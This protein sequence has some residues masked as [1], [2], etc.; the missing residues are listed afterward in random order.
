MK[1]RQKAS[2]SSTRGGFTLIELVASM[3]VLSV[4][5]LVAANVIMESMR[6]YA[7]A[8]PAMDA[9]YKSNLALRT[10]LRD[11]RD[12]DDLGSISTFGNTAFTFQDSNDTT[13]AYL[14]SGGRLTRNGDLLTDDV[15]SLTFSYLQK[16][17]TTASDAED[18]YLVEVDLT[19]RCSDQVLRA[20]TIA[21]PRSLG[22]SL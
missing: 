16:D 12:L 2:H 5:A 10:M 9:S 7:R 11:I 18:L 4:I 14:L 15:T 8:V 21:F 19:V 13:V 22:L 20:R 17:G 1:V 3:T 6:V